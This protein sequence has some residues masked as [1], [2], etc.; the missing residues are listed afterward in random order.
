MGLTIFQQLKSNG[1][2]RYEDI[3]S[4]THGEVVRNDRKWR[5]AGRIS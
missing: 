3:T 5:E 4:A 1:R 2:N